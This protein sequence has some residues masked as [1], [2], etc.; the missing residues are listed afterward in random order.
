M[1]M[2]TTKMNVSYVIRKL[3]VGLR[4]RC[5]NC[6]QGHMFHGLFAMD[7][8]CPHCGARYERLSG[9]SLGGMMINLCTA[10]VVSMGG[11]IISQA[12]FAPPLAFQLTFWVAFNI[13]FILLFYRH[14]RGIW[15]STA[16]LS[17]SVYPDSEMRQEQGGQGSSK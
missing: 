15:V 5:P 12:L 17:G 8:K 9:E 2:E 7:E 14:A 6:E 4:L 16:F 1:I 11:Y 10:E 13:I 3:W